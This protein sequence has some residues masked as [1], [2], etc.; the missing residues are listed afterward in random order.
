MHAV[1]VG[2]QAR[3]EDACMKMCFIHF[4]SKVI[5]HVHYVLS[6]LRI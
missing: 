4:A 6:M 1:V 3:P 2:K 5:D